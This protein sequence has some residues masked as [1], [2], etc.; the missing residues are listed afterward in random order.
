MRCLKYQ[1]LAIVITGTWGDNPAK[2]GGLFSTRLEASIRWTPLRLLREWSK[3]LVAVGDTLL[4]DAG[5]SIS[6]ASHPSDSW[7][8]VN[9]MIFASLLTCHSLWLT[10]MTEP[11]ELNN[12]LD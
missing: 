8:A 12:C 4:Q 2:N 7:D 3:K 6:T 5:I 10:E 11:R 9:R 1:I